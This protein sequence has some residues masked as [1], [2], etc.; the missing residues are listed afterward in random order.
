TGNE[1]VLFFSSLRGKLS[2]SRVSNNEGIPT[3]K[4]DMKVK[5]VKIKQFK[6][7]PTLLD[8][9]WNTLHIMPIEW[10]IGPVDVFISSDWTQPPSKAK[11]VTI[12]YDMIVYT[13]PEETDAKIVKVGKK[14]LEW[15]KKEVDR[16]ICISASSKEDAKK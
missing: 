9:L 16:I 7:P 11:K 8:I 5:S 3:I 4:S 6:L 13:Y 10:F 14:R 2:S 12:L 1:Y 15:V